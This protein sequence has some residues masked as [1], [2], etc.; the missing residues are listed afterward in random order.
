MRWWPWLL[1][2]AMLLIYL[3]MIQ[4][5][6][7]RDFYEL[8]PLPPQVLALLL[9]AAALWTAGVHLLRRTGIVGRVEDALWAAAV[10]AWRRV[11]PRR[12]AAG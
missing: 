4:V 3:V 9:G 6:F 11:R 10:G 1:S 2:G 5:P 12:A 8:T 7:L